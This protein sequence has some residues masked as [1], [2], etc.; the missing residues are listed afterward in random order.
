MLQRLALLTLLATGAAGAEDFDVLIRGG[1]VYD[2]SGA[3]PVRADVGIRGDRVAKVG[4]LAQA[5]AP[6]V[7]AAKGLAVAPGFINM[8]SWATDSLIVDGIKA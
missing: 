3:K 8:L 7:A 2:G 4:D 1:L 6:V 5:K